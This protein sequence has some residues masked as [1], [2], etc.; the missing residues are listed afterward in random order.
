MRVSQLVKYFFYACFLL[1][2]Q[3]LLLN[4]VSLANGKITPYLYHIFILWLP[5]SVNR[6]W[7]LIIAFIYGLT[8]D[9]F[10]KTQGLHAMGCLWIAFLRPIFVNLFVHQEGQE[11]NYVA[12]SYKVFGIARYIFY[13]FFLTLIHHFVVLLLTFLEMGNFFKFILN[14]ITFTLVSMFVIVAAELMIPRK[15]VYRT[16]T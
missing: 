3:I 5:F 9:F 15:E 11:L 2:V 4:N 14:T 16:N 13:V 12:P 8:Y 1:V 10:D 6:N 7:L